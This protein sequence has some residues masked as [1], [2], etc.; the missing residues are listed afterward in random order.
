MRFFATANWEVIGYS[1]LG[2]EAA[3]SRTRI[4]ATV[5]RTALIAW[6]VSVENTFRPTRAERI[7]DIVI[8]TDAIDGSVLRSALC[9]GTARI[10]ITRSR[11]LFYVWFDYSH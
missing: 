1:T 8:R 4:D 11:S 5:A 2:V 10:G 9:V 6:A 7:T 3:C